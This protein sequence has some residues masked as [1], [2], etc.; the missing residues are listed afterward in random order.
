MFTYENDTSL[1]K[2]KQQN[3]T[4][5]TSNITDCKCMVPLS[6]PNSSQRR[7]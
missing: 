4:L 5:T 3:N 1:Q 7:F 2:Q 6:Y